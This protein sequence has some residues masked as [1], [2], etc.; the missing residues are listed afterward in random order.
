MR[1]SILKFALIFFAA[2]LANG[3]GAWN[4][5]VLAQSR[6]AMTGILTFL[7]AMIGG[8]GT[9]AI[10]RDRWFYVLAWALGSVVGEVGSI[11]VDKNFLTGVR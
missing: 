3:I 1:S 6:Y 7:A 8:T 10:A 11:Y 9:R 4:I 5:R 2:V